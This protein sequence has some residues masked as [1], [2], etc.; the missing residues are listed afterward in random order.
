MAQLL[1][2]QSWS[3]LVESDSSQVGLLVCKERSLLKIASLWLKNIDKYF[4][5]SAAGE[6]RRGAGPYPGASAA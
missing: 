5:F 3:T 6:R 1:R 4:C 2:Q